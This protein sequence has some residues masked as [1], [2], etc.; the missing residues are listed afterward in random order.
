MTTI[1]AVI[2]AAGMGTRF[3][4]LTKA[5]PKEMLP[6]V[7]K[8]TIQ[9]VVEEAAEA[10]IKDIAIIIGKNKDAIEKH[11]NPL[12]EFEKALENSGKIRELQELQKINNIANIE[13]IIQEEQKGLGHAVLCAEDFVG[14]DPF[15]V[16][17]GDTI[18]VGSPNTTKGLVDLHK[19]IGK[20][21][22]AVE[23]V[24]L[25]ETSRYGIIS[26]KE[27][28][29]NLWKLD[30]MVEKPGPDL[31]P[32]RMAILGRYIFTPDIFKHQHD[33]RPGAGGEI[34]LTDAMHSLLLADDM[35]AWVFGGKRYDIGTMD[36]WFLSHLELSLQSD[37]SDMMKKTL[38]K[39]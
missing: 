28:D 5:Q 15:A 36:D 13:F 27:I 29:H 39:I 10:G 23:E 17:L 2:P 16:L 26:G 24:T 8:P 7:N 12:P 38:D 6:V 25:E 3:L 34:Q 1:K 20:S 11:F 19:K 4:P 9:W 33:T 31:A 35:Y 32:S 14:D 30:G 37:Y 22:F 18:C 21:I